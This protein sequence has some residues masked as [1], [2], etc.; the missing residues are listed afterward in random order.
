[1]KYL[2]QELHP[3]ILLDFEVIGKMRLVYAGQIIPDIIKQ[4][5]DQLRNLP[6]REH[7]SYNKKRLLDG[8]R[9]LNNGPIV[10]DFDQYTWDIFMFPRT[11]DSF[12]HSEFI[13]VVQ[14]TIL[15]TSSLSG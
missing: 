4:L 1:M 9:H 11:V 3:E 7:T 8:F 13:R 14:L 2:A 6:L 15:Q 10:H 12:S 5:N